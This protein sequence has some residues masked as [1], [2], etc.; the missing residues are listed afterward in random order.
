MFP[1][2]TTHFE[3]QNTPKMTILINLYPFFTIFIGVTVQICHRINRKGFLWS[4]VQFRDNFAN[5]ISFRRQKWFIL[6]ANLA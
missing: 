5:Q 3:P 4:W 1:T 2:K 6:V